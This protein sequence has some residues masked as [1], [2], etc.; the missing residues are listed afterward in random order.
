MN[1]KKYSEAMNQVGDK[2]YEEVLDYRKNAAKPVW[3][4][5]G[6]EQIGNVRQ[7][8]RYSSAG[9]RQRHKADRA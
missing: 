3:A 6:T 1:T 5:W 2:Y 4:R 8:I 9:K 7:F